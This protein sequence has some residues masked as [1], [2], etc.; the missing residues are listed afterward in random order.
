MPSRPDLSRVLEA[1]TA[2]RGPRRLVAIAGPP[3]AGKSTIAHDL[4]TALRAA[5]HGAA[6]VPMDGFHL[7]NALLAE[8]GLLSRKGAPETFDAAGFVH[9]AGRIAAGETVVYPV[10]D[11]AR[12]LSIA[13][14]AELS[15]D[16]AFVL[17]E[18]NYLLCGVTPWDR[19]LPL[20]SLRILLDPGWET[21]S[22]RLLQRWLDLGHAREDALRRRDENDLPN[23]RFVLRHSLGADLTL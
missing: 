16:V 5:G 22:D 18:G 12:D 2:V 17:F 8:R 7:D 10:F 3:G 23:A 6:V 4:C 20:W 11:R 13:G 14:A 9:L 1:L 15:G 19:L 21:I